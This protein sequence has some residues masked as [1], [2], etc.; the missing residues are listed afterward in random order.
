MKKE[1]VELISHSI[2]HL[3]LFLSVLVSYEK[4]IPKF[5]LGEEFTFPKTLLIRYGRKGKIDNLRQ[6]RNH[7]RR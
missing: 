6:E 7:G 3:T 1:G 5:T 4:K 2:R